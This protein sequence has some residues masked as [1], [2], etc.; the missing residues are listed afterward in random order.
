MSTLYD[1]YKRK[2]SGG[3]GSAESPLDPMDRPSVLLSQENHQIL[4]AN[5][6]FEQFI[7]YPSNELVGQP[8]EKLVCWSGDSARE[9][10]WERI[11]KTKEGKWRKGQVHRS[12][13]RLCDV[14]LKFTRGRAKK[15]RYCVLQLIDLSNRGPTTRQIFRACER[16]QRFLGYQLNE[17]IRQRLAGIALMCSAIGEELPEEGSSNTAQQ[18]KDITDMLLETQRRVQQ[19]SRNVLPRQLAG[20]GFVTAL[21]AFSRRMEQKYSVSCTV[22]AKKG[23][24]VKDPDRAINLYRIAQEAVINAIQ[25]GQ[26][27]VVTIGLQQEQDEKILTVEDNGRRISARTL[28]KGHRGVAMMRYRASLID[29][30]Y[31]VEPHSQNGTTVQ[32]RVSGAVDK[33]LSTTADKPLSKEVGAALKPKAGLQSFLKG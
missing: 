25:Y 27:G 4:E 6:L 1:S 31:K 32:C 3:G 30:W 10:S 19:I 29:A 28:R 12:D 23:I 21:R 2:S 13:G 11:Y 20:E 9:A 7:G 8:V 18:L 26:A 33:Q 22:K 24:V 17:D 16:E 14:F 5:A 15:T